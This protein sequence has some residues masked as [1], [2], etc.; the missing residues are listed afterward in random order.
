MCVQSCPTLCDP[1]DCSLPG[2]SVCGIFQA[3]ILEWLPF[4][5]PG[6]LPDPGIEPGSPALQE[7]SLSTEEWIKKIWYIY[8]VD[9]KIHHNL[10]VDL[11]YLVGMLRT[12]SLGDHFSSHEKTALKRQEKESGYIRVC[13]IGSRQS[14][15]QRL[16]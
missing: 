6:D 14:E 12:P 2:S 7:D 3:R 10:K 4:P 5:L 13:N 11:F 8:T 1:M 9:E 16:L 15:H